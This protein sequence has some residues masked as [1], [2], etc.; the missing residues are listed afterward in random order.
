MKKPTCRL[1]FI[2]STLVLSVERES[3]FCRLDSSLPKQL[4]LGC[5]GE[6]VA[7]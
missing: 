2:R 5:K 6:S 3:G 4:Y 1:M 7:R